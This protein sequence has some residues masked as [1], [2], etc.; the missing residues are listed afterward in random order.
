MNSSAY[1]SL[2]KMQATQFNID[3]RLLCAIATVESGWNTFAVRYEPAWEYIF[4]PKAFAEKNRI[5]VDT[6]VQLQKF[7]YGLC[8]IMGAVARENGL[9]AEIHRLLEPETGLFYGAK[10]LRKLCDRYPDSI[11]DVMSAYNAGHPRRDPKTG[12]YFNQ[13]YVN[14][15]QA[16]FDIALA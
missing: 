14:R 6:E 2:A 7:S 12:L 13:D 1:M 16:V 15:V 10:L 4:Q 3:P 9:F 11:Q 8:Q 5:T